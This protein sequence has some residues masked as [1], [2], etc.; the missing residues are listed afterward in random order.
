[1][2][3]YDFKVLYDLKDKEVMKVA[4]DSLNPKLDRVQ[5]IIEYARFK[6]YWD[7]QLYHI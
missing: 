7:S 3:N 4:E 1:M 5:E 2:D 6:N